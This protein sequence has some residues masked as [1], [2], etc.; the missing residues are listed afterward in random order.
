VEEKVETK[1]EVV[2]NY[3][4]IVDTIL[5]ELEGATSPDANGE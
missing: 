1:K 5:N 2:G 3:L 4:E